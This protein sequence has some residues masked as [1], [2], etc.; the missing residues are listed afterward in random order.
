MN[1]LDRRQADVDNDDF[2][3]TP[4]VWVILERDSVSPDPRDLLAR[5]SSVR[6]RPVIGGPSRKAR[7]A[8][9]GRSAGRIPALI[10]TG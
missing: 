6:G 2:C 7:R 10:S 5:P 1:P 3:A 8:M 9:P 4:P